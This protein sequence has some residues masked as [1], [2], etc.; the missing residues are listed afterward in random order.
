MDTKKYFDILL[1]WKNILFLAFGTVVLATALFTLT[2][3]PAYEAT[4][5]LVILP[6]ANVFTNYN[7]V[8]NAITSLDNDYVANTYA[9]VAQ[10]STIL[11]SAQSA[12]GLESLDGYVVTSSVEPKTNLLSVTVEGPDAYTVY[13]LSNMVATTTTEYV[14]EYFDIY[15]LQHLDKAVLPEK[16]IRPNVALNLVLG[17]IL[18]L[19]AGVVFAYFGEYLSE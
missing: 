1:K 17:V 14:A 13:A 16:P 10:S 6:S 12:L 19:G 11:E 7:D 3:T 2:S 18:G 8:R 9:E 5:K 4:S 15:Y